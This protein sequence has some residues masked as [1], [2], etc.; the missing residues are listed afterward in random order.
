[1]GG[2]RAWEIQAGR[3]CGIGSFIWC[4][5]M[6]D[7][8]SLLRNLARHRI[9]M[10]KDGRS[11]CAVAWRMDLLW[12]AGL[13]QKDSLRRRRGTRPSPWL[14][15]DLWK[16]SPLRYRPGFFNWLPRSALTI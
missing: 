11:G 5:L 3:V 8:G 1:M 6:P 9:L 16:K 7:S 10:R 4:R 14:R 15:L 2:V 12:A 13:F